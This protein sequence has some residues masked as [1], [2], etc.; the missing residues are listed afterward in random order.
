MPSGD[1]LEQAVQDYLK[2]LASDPQLT[3]EQFCEGMPHLL[4]GLRMV[5]QAITL[6]REASHVLT[7]PKGGAAT[8]TVA[9]ELRRIDRDGSPQGGSRQRWLLALPLVLLFV[10]G[11][12]FI[13]KA[14]NKGG[15][16]SD[17]NDSET[18][19]PAGPPPKTLK[20]TIGM[21]FVRVGKGT[22][23]LGAGP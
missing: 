17:F 9:D 22:A 19:N 14:T 13:I 3:P 15:K 4:A 1:T 6:G 11:G 21:E 10:I 2:A 8:S 20:N 18:A 16:P 5:S 12:F 23:W 7:Q